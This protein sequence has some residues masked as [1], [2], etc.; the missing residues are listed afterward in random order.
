MRLTWTKS[1]PTAPG[2]YWVRGFGLPDHRGKALVEVEAHDGELWSNLH[3]RNS[4]RY[5]DPFAGWSALADTSDE[6]EWCGPLVPPNK[7]STP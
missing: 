7:H 2:A 1:K 3:Q 6:F 4:E 5:N